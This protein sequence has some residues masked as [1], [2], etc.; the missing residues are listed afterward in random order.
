[1]VVLSRG[2]MTFVPKFLLKK[3]HI[4][5]QLR[6]PISLVMRC[7]ALFLLISGTIVSTSLRSRPK[8]LRCGGQ[9]PASTITRQAI[10]SEVPVSWCQTTCRPAC[11]RGPRPPEEFEAWRA[12][13]KTRK[14]DPKATSAYFRSS[15]L[16]PTCKIIY[17]VLFGG[18]RF[19]QRGVPDARMRRLWRTPWIRDGPSPCE[20]ETPCDLDRA[21]RMLAEVGQTTDCLR[22]ASEL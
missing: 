7:N 13:E 8:N 17:R 6:A 22:F 4:N 12:S 10:L 15:Q 19:H 11:A 21:E 9:P 2:E 18:C 3:D 20:P 5:Y 14:L 1:M 16:G